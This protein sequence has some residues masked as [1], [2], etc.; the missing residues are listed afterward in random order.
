MDLQNVLPTILAALTDYPDAKIVV[1]A[2]LQKLSDADDEPQ[3]D[4]LSGDR[5]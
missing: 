4:Q 1:A 3:P 2:A 5:A